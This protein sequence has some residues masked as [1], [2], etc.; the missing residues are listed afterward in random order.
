MLVQ[1]EKGRCLALSRPHGGHATRIS[2]GQGANLP[3]GATISPDFWKV[4]GVGFRNGKTKR[5]KYS[6]TKG[7]W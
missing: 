3:N 6:H 2:M 5:S 1:V 4:H 7:F